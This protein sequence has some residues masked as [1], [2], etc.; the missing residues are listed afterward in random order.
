MV[1][2]AKGFHEECALKTNRLFAAFWL[3]A[4]IKWRYGGAAG[5][6][7]ELFSGRSVFVAWLKEFVRLKGSWTGP[8]ASMS[9]ILGSHCAQSAR[10]QQ[11][12]DKALTLIGEIIKSSDF[13]PHVFYISPYYIYLCLRNLMSFSKDGVVVICEETI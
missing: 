2:A 3:P 5:V 1:F 7:A 6:A 9:Y 11:T 13:N 4:M 12:Q 10:L 8:G